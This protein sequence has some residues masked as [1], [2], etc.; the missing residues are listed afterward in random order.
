MTTPHGGDYSTEIAREYCNYHPHPLIYGARVPEA[1]QNWYPKGIMQHYLINSWVI[2]LHLS[3]EVSSHFKFTVKE[4]LL[5][6]P[7]IKCN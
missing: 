3:M 6:K 2:P 5:R 4:E 7:L 1:P